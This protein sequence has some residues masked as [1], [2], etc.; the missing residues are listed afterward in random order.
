[1]DGARDAQL[2]GQLMHTPLMHRRCGS[3]SCSRVV[4]VLMALCADGESR[5]AYR[6]LT[7]GV[8]SRGLLN[9]ISNLPT[10]T[11]KFQLW[12]SMRC[13]ILTRPTWSAKGWLESFVWR[14]A[15]R[16]I[17]QLIVLNAR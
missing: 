10:R 9:K 8:P 7:R 3:E 4:V 13:S 1:M 2:R 15:D 6:G 17:Q 16:L 5:G 12:W 11:T 14:G